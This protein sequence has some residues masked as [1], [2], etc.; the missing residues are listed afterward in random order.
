MSG[1]LACL[2][3]VSTLLLVARP[4]YAASDCVESSFA[5]RRMTLPKYTLRLDDGPYWPL[6]SGLVELSFI[7]TGP[8]HD[9]RTALNFGAGFGLLE[10][11]EVGAHVVKYSNSTFFAPSVY[12]LFRFL[13]KDAELGAYAE[14]TPRLGDSPTF[15]VGMPVS[16]HLGE[17]VR[18]DTG[19]FMLFP[20][21]TNTDAVFIAPLQ[22]PINVTPEVYL[23]PEAG[24]TWVEFDQSDFLLGFFAGYTLT[25]ARGTW[26]DFGGRFRV[27]STEVGLDLFQILFELDIFIDI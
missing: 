11:L 22:V 16:V 6:P 3:G 14:I 18:L 17:S 2:L 24:F 15:L 5:P 12:G 19:P 4:A 10:S 9:T 13:D 25:T 1:R 26:G 27:P 7:D 21:E 8:Q 20:L 23:G